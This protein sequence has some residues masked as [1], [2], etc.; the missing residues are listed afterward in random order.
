[1]ISPKA[2]K[3]NPESGVGRKSAAHSAK[4]ASSTGGLRLRS[5]ASALRRERLVEIA[6]Q[7]LR[8]F[9]ADR[10]ADDVRTGAGCLALIVRALA[11]GRRGGVQDQA[12]RVADIG[13]M[14]EQ[15]HAFDKPDA[16]L[17]AA[18]DPKR[19]DRA[20][21]LRQVFAG[22]VMKRV[23]LEPGIRNPG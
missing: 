21:A 4:S 7:V 23:V 6:D 8:R 5:S 22:E 14:R 2:H 3:L 10:Q 20:G 15:L 12:A 13:E 18:L 1:D 9:E 11:V 16:G 19:E 17:V